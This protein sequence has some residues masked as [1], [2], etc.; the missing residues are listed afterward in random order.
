M[1]KF[2]S[3]LLAAVMLFTG[4]SFAVYAAETCDC[5]HAPI[6]FVDGF[7]ASDLIRDPGTD[8]E[9]VVF[10]FPAEG[11]VNMIKDNA[12]AVWDMLD[13]RFDAATEQ[14]VADAIKALLA[15]TEMTDDG[16]SL[17]DVAVDWTY[18]TNP[19]HSDGQYFKFH[20]D[21]RLDPFLNAEGLRDYIAYVKELTGHD[22]VHL[23]GFSQGATVVNTYLA[24]YGYEGLETVIWYCGAQNG[25]ALVGSLFTGGIRL[26]A[27]AVTGYVQNAT[28]DT[29]LFNT[30]SALLQGLTDIGVTGGV[31]DLVNVSL[32]HFYDDGV[33]REIF[34]DT[35][36]KMPG[37]WTLVPYEDY[38]AAKR[39]V[40]GEG[41]EA[42]PYAALIEKLDR[43]HNE[44]QGN[45]A[46]I[47]EAA[48]EQVG[49]IGVIAKYNVRM[50]PVVDA[51]NVQAD[52]LI[53][54]RHA[55]CGATC[56][57]FGDTLGDGYVQKIDDG[58]NHL[59]ADGI[60]DASTALF[61]DCTWFIK[62]AV[63]ETYI[64]YNDALLRHI[65]DSDHQPD[66]FEDEAYPQFTYYS[67]ATGQTSP[68]TKDT[69]ERPDLKPIERIMAFFRRIAAFWREL[70]EKLFPKVE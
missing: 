48:K 69:D 49:R 7:N 61:P 26:D 55:S 31:L 64:P 8:R 17:Y 46:A 52:S 35:F 18:P 54:T 65:C 36:G 44:V 45:C 68:L 62:N 38:D 9:T 70:F 15:G 29:F 6:V 27:K 30:L 23:I 21:W 28:E 32:R 24:Q 13:T 1:K 37:V 58:H 63:H 39:F 5:G 40:F 4:L 66:V 14:Q 11:V 3:V 12:D 34:L 22:T 42:A 47:M 60:I 67:P 33:M 25:T 2:L 41:E 43:Y 50:M 53:D 51:A 16:A 59:S 57:D 10:P 20:F 56:A 19:A